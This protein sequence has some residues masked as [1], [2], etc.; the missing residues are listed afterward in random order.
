M[1]TDDE[2]TRDAKKLKSDALPERDLWSDIEARLDAQPKAN[3][4]W[5]YIAAAA[6]LL[7]VFIAGLSWRNFY[8]TQQRNAFLV[9]LQQQHQ[10]QL[11]YLYSNFEDQEALAGNWQE[12]LAELESAAQEILKALEDDP[13]NI[14][15]LKMLMRVYQQKLM[16]VERVHNPKW[17][18]IYQSQGKVAL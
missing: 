7:T 12:Q 11:R 17:Q 2:L 8:E 1:N 4:R 5:T 18:Y 6:C 16:L 9:E 15:L 10:Q 13:Q 3:V 14:D